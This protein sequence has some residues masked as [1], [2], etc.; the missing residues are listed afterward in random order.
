MTATLLTVIGIVIMALCTAGGFVYYDIDSGSALEGGIAVSQSISALEEGASAFLETTGT[1]PTSIDDLKSI[2]DLP[3][4]PKFAGAAWM[5]GREH[6][7]VH[8]DRGEVEDRSLRD[9]ARRL[10]A[11]AMVSGQCGVP[12]DP[13]STSIVLSYPMSS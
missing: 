6:V 1:K 13:T 8:A 11:K 2:S 9:A 5:I 4:L 10:G 3:M 7:C 12:G